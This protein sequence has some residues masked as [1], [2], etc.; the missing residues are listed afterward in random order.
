MAKTDKKK[1]FFNTNMNMLKKLGIS[2]GIAQKLSAEEFENL[3]AA[4]EKLNALESENAQLS[5]QNG[6]LSAQVVELNGK[7][8]ANEKSLAEKD[9]K[10]KELN[11]KLNE[12]P[13]APATTAV[14]QSEQHG[15]DTS[16][17]YETS[18]DR[19]KKSI[20]NSIN[21]N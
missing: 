12:T 15:D 8:E 5:E 19:E 2:W 4:D 1:T 7:I 9:A 17:K 14:P 13:A 6:T 16:K 18:V 3:E 10:I 11:D 20:L 21:N